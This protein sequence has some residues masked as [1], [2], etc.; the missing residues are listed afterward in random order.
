MTGTPYQCRTNWCS[1]SRHCLHHPSL[2]FS[3]HLTIKTDAYAFCPAWSLENSRLLGFYLL[4]EMHRT[5]YMVFQYSLK[6]PEVSICLTK[7]RKP[8]V[9]I[10]FMNT[11]DWKIGW[12]S[13]LLFYFGSLCGWFGWLCTPGAQLDKLAPAEVLNLQMQRNCW[14][15]NTKTQQEKQIFP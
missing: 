2:F 11:I 6:S 15:I 3:M 14:R 1:I 10:F 4:Q 7:L 12:I 13:R 9:N 5:R 8:K